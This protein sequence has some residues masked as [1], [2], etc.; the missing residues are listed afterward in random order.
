MN[1]D[2]CINLLSTAKACVSVMPLITDAH[3]D[4]QTFGQT[5]CV[6]CYMPSYAYYHKDRQ[7]HR[8][9]IKVFITKSAKKLIIIE[10][11]VM[12]TEELNVY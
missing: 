1:S 12:G 10:A 9:K 4:R 6:D 2:V 5:A 3:T 11:Y 8:N 7:M